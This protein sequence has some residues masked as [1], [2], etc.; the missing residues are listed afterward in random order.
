M[1]EVLPEPGREFVLSS[2]RRLRFGRGETILSQGS[3]S[4]S[5]L[6]IE[7]GR[8]SIHLLTSDSEN[9]ILGV[10]G[11]GEVLGEMGLLMPTRERTASVRAVDEVTIRALRRE[12]FEELRRSHPSVS[13]FLIHLLAGRADRLSQ[14][15]LEAYHVPVEQRVA[16]RLLEV[17]RLFAAE[18]L[19]VVVPLT[20]DEV[21]QLAGTRRPTANQILRGFQDAGLL[22]LVRG[23]VEL[24]DIAGLRQRC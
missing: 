20:Q 16:R 2:A 13:D 7:S 11:P 23:R 6:I 1:L 10:M 17:G 22:R 3:A 5:L 12:S 14:L 21:A 18:R 24:L 19:P 9:V 15:V 4:A 8:V